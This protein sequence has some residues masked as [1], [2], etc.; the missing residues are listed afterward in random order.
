VPCLDW[1]RRVIGHCECLLLLR[2]LLLLLPVLP[3]AAVL[4]LQAALPL[5]LPALPPPVA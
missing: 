4:L 3:L 1:R 2:S 5:Q